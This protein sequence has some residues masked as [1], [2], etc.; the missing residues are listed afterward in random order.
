MNSFKNF[1]L[2]TSLIKC[3]LLMILFFSVSSKSVAQIKLPTK[4]SDFDNL[5]IGVLDFSN[6]L[7]VKGSFQSIFSTEYNKNSVRIVQNFI[8][9]KDAKVGD[10]TI[11]F[12]VGYRLYISITNI[13]ISG[14]FTLTQLS[15]AVTIGKA[16]ASYKFSVFGFPNINYS[17]LPPTSNFDANAYNQVRAYFDTL[18]E[19]LTDTTAVSPIITT[20][21]N[22]SK[23]NL[24]RNFD[25]NS[26]K[27]NQSDTTITESKTLSLIK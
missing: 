27:A 17:K 2:N 19:A 4:L 10:S 11:R 26:L 3:I 18:V 25:A 7:D 8:R 12:F 16:K 5:D 24:D 9:Y 1:I 15:A 13:K 6:S 21:R 22:Y 20:V 14:N 23:Y